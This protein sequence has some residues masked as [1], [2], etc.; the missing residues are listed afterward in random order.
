MDD[1][2]TQVAPLERHQVEAVQKE[3]FTTGDLLRIG[4][5]EPSLMEGSSPAT[6]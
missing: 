1:G 4:A 2:V 6:R 3:L 5:L